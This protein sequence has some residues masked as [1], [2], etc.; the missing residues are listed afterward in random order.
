MNLSLLLAIVATSSSTFVQVTFDR[1]GIPRIVA[2]LGQSM[3][4]AHVVHFGGHG[5]TIVADEQGTS[6]LRPVNLGFDIPT[7]NGEPIRNVHHRRVSVPG[8]SSTFGIGPG[9]DLLRVWTSINFVRQSVDRGFLRLGGSV[10]EFITNDCLPDSIMRMQPVIGDDSTT[11][12]SVSIGENMVANSSVSF[13]YSEH[14]LLIMPDTWLANIDAEIRPYFVPGTVLSNCSHTIPRLP[15]ITISFSAGVV[16]LVPEDYT[17]PTG[18]GEDTC[19][20]LIGQLPLWEAEWTIRL[21]PLLIPG[22]NARSTENEIILCDS[23]V[24]L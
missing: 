6:S 11:R 3:E 22:I 20:V 17:R 1:S 21:N 7:I 12:I 15:I 24:D 10:Q 5:A 2:E 14:S 9:S 19:E 8:E 13:H 16:R 18:Q 23:S 4:H